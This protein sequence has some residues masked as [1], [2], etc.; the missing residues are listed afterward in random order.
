[1]IFATGSLG[2]RVANLFSSWKGFWPVDQN[3]VVSTRRCRLWLLHLKQKETAVSPFLMLHAAKAIHRQGRVNNIW[4]VHEW[5]YNYSLGCVRRAFRFERIVIA[6]TSGAKAKSVAFYSYCWR[7]D[8]PIE[9]HFAQ[10]NKNASQNIE[11]TRQ[12]VGFILTWT[13]TQIEP[14]EA[15]WRTLPGFS[16]KTASKNTI[17]TKFWKMWVRHDRFVEVVP[18]HNSNKL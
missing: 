2:S 8:Y 9:M 12:S 1:M 13:I 18:C 11:I 16:A 17:A 7:L 15:A 3:E 5:S 4:V 6:H 10:H 14:R